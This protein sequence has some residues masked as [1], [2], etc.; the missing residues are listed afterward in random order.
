MYRISSKFLILVIIISMIISGCVSESK[1]ESV[2]EVN[3]DK[4]QSKVEDTERLKQNNNDRN[5]NGVNILGKVKNITD[6]EIVLELAEMPERKGRPEDGEN[7]EKQSPRRN[8]ENGG[9]APQGMG[10]GVQ[11]DIEFTGDTITLVIPVEASISSMNQGEMKE[12]DIAE[13]Y[14]GS[15]LQI[16]FDENE[17]ITSIII[18]GEN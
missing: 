11:R 1:I 9:M 18:V 12:V 16:W 5:I 17:T 8:N 10:S 7:G 6:N 15:I 2:Q 4:A 14:E 3:T 13:I